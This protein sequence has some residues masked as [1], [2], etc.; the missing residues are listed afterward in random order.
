M[1]KMDEEA[2]TEE[3]RRVTTSV[4]A[5]STIIQKRG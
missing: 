4:N 5:D 2:A 3:F 1:A